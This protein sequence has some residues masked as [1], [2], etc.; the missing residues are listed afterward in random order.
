MKTIT[1]II[2][3]DGKTKI[4]THGFEGKTCAESSKFL[5]A[6]LGQ[7]TAEQFKPEYFNEQTE[8]LQQGE[9]IRC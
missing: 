4:E 2:S 1:L 7:K 6:A 5:A 8:N 3:P 9:R